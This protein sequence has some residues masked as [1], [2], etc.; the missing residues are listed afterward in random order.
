MDIESEKKARRKRI[1][2]EIETAM[3]NK[4][5]TRKEFASAMHRMPSEVTKWLG[6]NHNFTSDLLAEISFVLGTA[7]SG[8]DDSF[9]DASALVKGYSITDE[10]AN[11]V[12]EDSGLTLI[13]NIDIPRKTTIAL[14]IKAR[15]NGMTLREYIRHILDED[16][17][18]KEPSIMDFCGIWNEGYPSAEEIRMARTSNTF[19]EL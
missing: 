18:R 13:N 7:I 15:N 11:P 3:H 14:T 4:G 6:G 19:P 16:A 12:L 10:D 8:A 5:Y 1:A 2:E 9:A 17:S